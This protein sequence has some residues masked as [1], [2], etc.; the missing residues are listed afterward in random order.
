[1]PV[2]RI[3]KDYSCQFFCNF[4]FRLTCQPCHIGKINPCFFIQRN[5]QSFRRSFHTG[6]SHCFLNRPL[7]K[8]IRFPFQR[9]IF[10]KILQRTEQTIRRVIRKCPFVCIAS[11][12][13]V[14]FRIDIIDL[15]QFDLKLPYRLIRCIFLHLQGDQVPDYLTNLYHTLYT[16][17]CGCRQLHRIHQGIYPVID[18]VIH[19][20]KTV[21]SDRRIRRNTFHDLIQFCFCRYCRNHRSMDLRCGIFQLFRQVCPFQRKAGSLHA[22][23]SGHLCHCSKYHFRMG[24]KILVYGNPILILSKS[25][26]FRLFHGNALPLL[27]KQNVGTDFGSRIRLKSIVRKTDRT[28]KF[29]PLCKILPYFRRCFIHSS[30]CC[31]QGSH[32][33]RS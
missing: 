9:T 6:H 2:D 28:E 12:D 31:D 3:P 23:R 1:M 7:G 33:T 5:R 11:D 26:P 29:C 30:L 15:I 24:N 19:H 22:I 13:P 18:L 20:G 16:F 14:F 4:L 25:N 8:H 17:R 21:V 27:E 10:I 32:S